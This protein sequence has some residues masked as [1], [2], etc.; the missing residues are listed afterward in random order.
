[1]IAHP[2]GFILRYGAIHFRGCVDQPDW[3]SLRK[4]WYGDHSFHRLYPSVF[5]TDIPFAQDQMGDQYLLRSEEVFRLDAE[6]GKVDRFASDLESF[7][8]GIDGDIAAYLNVGL[9]HQLEPGFLLLAYPPF[10]MA[11]SSGG[12]SLRPVPSGE[13]ILFHADLAAQIRDVP[14]GGK[15]I[16]TATE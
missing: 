15:V 9:D 16:I 13:L 4:A 1:M 8:A 11:E 10:C 5:E 3:H 7:M 12:A 2:A 14:D 6:T